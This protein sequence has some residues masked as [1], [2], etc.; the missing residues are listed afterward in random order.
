MAGGD[1]SAH[2][3]H[4]EALI[5]ADRAVL[6]QLRCE[7]DG[8]DSELRV[9]HDAGRQLGRQLQRQ[10]EEG[11]VLDVQQRELEG[12]LQAARQCL[13]G[14]CDD[15]RA[16]SLEAVSLRHDRE[17]CRE[18]LAFLQRTSGEE[19]RL[20][21]AIWRANELL[22]RSNDEL[23]AETG[24]LERQ[25]REL[26][27]Q[28]AEERELKRIQERET[29]EL[30]SRLE[31]MRREQAAAFERHKEARAREQRIQDMKCDKLQWPV[32]VDRGANREGNTWAA[33]LTRPSNDGG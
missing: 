29:A 11:D 22:E 12:R 5:A 30:R 24:A 23:A 9:L 8:L 27:Q 33:A 10:R 21:E 18:E 16:A 6:Q 19:A 31:R 28:V 4:F 7:V 14:A 25:R 13:D 1:P 26:L 20:L 32:A 15:R 3:A 2:V 17:H